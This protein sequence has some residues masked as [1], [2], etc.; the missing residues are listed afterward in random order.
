M[1]PEHLGNKLLPFALELARQAETEILPLFLNVT[2]ER[3]A[4]G[5]E[6]TEADRQAEVRMRAHIQTHYPDHAILGEE[7]GRSGPEDAR[8]CWVL[9]PIDGTAGF[10][11]GV[12]LFGTLVG[13]L[14]DG[15]PV[16]GVIH[17]PG[18]DETVY[19]A[20]GSGCW[21]RRGKDLPRRVHTSTCSRLDEAVVSSTGIE[22]TDL[23]SPGK[24]AFPLSEMVGKVRK[25]RFVTDCAQYALVARG[26]VDLAFDP[27]MSPW[28]IAALVPCIEEAGG[29][30]ASTK[31]GERAGVVF[32]GS[33][34]VSSTPALLQEAF[35]LLRAN[36][37]AG[38]R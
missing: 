31:T 30:V 28:D 10:T 16:L 33:L 4:D 9:D 6:V 32:G 19:A 36:G 11:I 5:T 35:N 23:V 26:L 17:L 7:Q 18:L 24:G 27:I 34:I 22:S 25:F 2:A 8:F 13:L 15:E 21:Y 20:K 38:E 1:E 3:K 37:W 29:A 14:E 12:P